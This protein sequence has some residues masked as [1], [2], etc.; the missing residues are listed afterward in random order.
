M[1]VVEQAQRDVGPP[2]RE[3]LD[4]PRI[5]ELVALSLEDQRRHRDD[6]NTIILNGSFVRLRIAAEPEPWDQPLLWKID[7]GC[8]TGAPSATMSK[9]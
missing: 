3:R 7:P 9:L 2:R 8:P 1:V 4:R 6:S 5:D